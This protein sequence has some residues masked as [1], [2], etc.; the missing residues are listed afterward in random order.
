MSLSPKEMH[1]LRITGNVNSENL[2]E[3]WATWSPVS[4]EGS[5]C[6][7]S[8][9]TCKQ[10]CYWYYISTHKGHKGEFDDRQVISVCVGETAFHKMIAGTAGGCLDSVILW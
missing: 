8:Y 5:K 1:Y 7:L 10:L 2:P 9:H 3:K 6:K 4:T